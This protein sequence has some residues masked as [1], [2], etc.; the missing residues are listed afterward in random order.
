MLIDR[1]ANYLLSV[2][3]NRKIRVV[4][5]HNYLAPFLG[6]FNAR[7]KQFKYSL[8][9]Q[10]FFRLIDDERG[11]VLID[12]QVENQKKGPTLTWRKFGKSLPCDSKRIPGTQII[13]SIN[14]VIER[15]CSLTFLHDVLNI[16]R[17]LAVT[18]ID[19]KALDQLLDERC[20]TGVA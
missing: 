15:L 11:I 2:A 19:K 3:H 5:D 10:I 8:I 7:N 17:C 12:Q 20:D 6:L 18:L 14:E 4:R 16:C 13:Q 1:A 9:V